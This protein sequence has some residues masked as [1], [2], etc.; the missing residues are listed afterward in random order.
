MFRIVEDPQFV[1]DV[2][3]TTPDGDSWEAQILRTRFRV[4]PLAEVEA[5]DQ[6]DGSGP[7]GVAAILERA[8]VEFLNLADEKGNPMPG[9]GDVRAQLL[10]WPHIRAALLRGY[11]AAVVRERLGNSVPSAASGRPAH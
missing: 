9:T 5:L 6:G 7:R 4:L 10:N 1:E 2:R 8:V 3:V 11:S